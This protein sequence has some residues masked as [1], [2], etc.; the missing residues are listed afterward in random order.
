M[1]QQIVKARKGEEG[2]ATRL[3]RASGRDDGALGDEQATLGGPLR[4]V[5][6]QRRAGHPAD[7]PAPRHRRQHHPVVEA[8]A[9]HLVRREERRLLL[10]LLI[11]RRP[12]HLSRCWIARRKGKAWGGG[13]H[14]GR[15]GKWRVGERAEEGNR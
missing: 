2:E 6:R 9:G 3:P 13:C 5:L 14:C 12:I 1:C 15:R 10:P 7:R 8:E 11:R 4:V